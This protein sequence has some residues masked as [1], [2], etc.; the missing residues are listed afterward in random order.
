MGKKPLKERPPRLDLVDAL[1]LEVHGLVH[2]QA[3]LA[4]RALERVVRR[5]RKL[6]AS[7]RRLVA[8]G[9]ETLVEPQ[10]RHGPAGRRERARGSRRELVDCARRPRADHEGVRFIAKRPAAR[11]WART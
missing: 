2:D 1:V 4:D 3:W 5:E 10:E 9:P 8:L 7:E 6:W 11:R